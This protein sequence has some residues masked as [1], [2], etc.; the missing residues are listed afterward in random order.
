M[1][2]KYVLD[3]S[4]WLEYL[5]GS[6]KGARIHEII[7]ERTAAITILALAELA[8]K[9]ERENRAFEKTLQFIQSKSPILSLNISIIQGAAKIKK[10]QRLSQSKFGLIDALHLAT[11]KYHGAIF[12]T[13]DLDFKGIE[14]VVI[15]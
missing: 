3:S 10:K 14:N 8:D 15:L 5:E 13:K 1:S 9:F 4:A 12:I 7:E 2:F 11:A 6:E